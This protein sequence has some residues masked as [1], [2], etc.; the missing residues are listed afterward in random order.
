MATRDVT[1]VSKPVVHEY[2]PRT[3]CCAERS[4]EGAHIIRRCV[5][6]RKTLDETGRIPPCPG[7]SGPDGT[8]AGSRVQPFSAPTLSIL[9]FQE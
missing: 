6:F 4:N 3:P 5:L 8:E 9:L 2:V 7:R 1:L